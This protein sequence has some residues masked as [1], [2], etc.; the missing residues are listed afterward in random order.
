MMWS[1][2]KWWIT[3]KLQG[4][5]TCCNWLFWSLRCC[6]IEFCHVMQGK[7]IFKILLHV[8]SFTDIFLKW[9]VTPYFLFIFSS[10]YHLQSICKNI[11]NLSWQ[12]F[13]K[14]NLLHSIETHIKSC[15]TEGSLLREISFS[16]SHYF[17]ISQFFPEWLPVNYK[18]VRALGLLC[19]AQILPIDIAR[20]FRPQFLRNSAATG[21]VTLQSVGEN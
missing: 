7:I 13:E 9:L 8:I 14:I 4:L 20:A 6:K 12:V 1:S 5:V 15:S 16:F 19:N 10:T 21:S 3:L 2:R 17:F 18:C 11:K